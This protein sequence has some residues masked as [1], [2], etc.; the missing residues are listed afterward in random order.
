MLNAYQKFWDN[1]FNFRGT[2]TIIEFWIPLIFNYI[3][4]FLI[5][6]LLGLLAGTVSGQLVSII[7]GIMFLLAWIGSISV[8]VRRFHDSNHSGWWFWIQIIPVIGD[9]WLL[10]LLIIPTNHASRWR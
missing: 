6:W 7:Y 3:L 1:L 9:F 10:I 4:A 2:A 5:A 8:T